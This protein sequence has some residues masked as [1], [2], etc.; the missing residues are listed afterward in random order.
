MALP[1]FY[2]IYTKHPVRGTPGWDIQVGFVTGAPNR[3]GAKR[4]IKKTFGRLFD[5]VIQLYEVTHV[6][7]L[8]ADQYLV[9]P[10]NNPKDREIRYGRDPYPR[11]A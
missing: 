6:E 2:E 8:Y 11:R 10:Y 1:Y 4:A 3:E 7:P 5:T 9:I